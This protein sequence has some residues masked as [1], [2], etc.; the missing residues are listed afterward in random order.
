MNRLKLVFVDSGVDR[1]HPVLKNDSFDE[2]EL[3]HSSNTDEVRQSGH[4]TAVYGILR[5]VRNDYDI[6][7]I[8]LNGVE[9]GVSCAELCEVME[10]IENNVDCSQYMRLN[11]LIETVRYTLPKVVLEGFLIF[12]L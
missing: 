2:I 12:I 3:L 9:N 10:Y 7:S 1:S 6:L 5:S 4:G 8:K 11:R